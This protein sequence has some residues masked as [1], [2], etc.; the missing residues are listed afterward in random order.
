MLTAA[1]AVELRVQIQLDRTTVHVTMVTGEMEKPVVYPKVSTATC[2]EQYWLRR[3]RA[4]FN[5]GI[6]NVLIDYSSSKIIPGLIAICVKSKL[7]LC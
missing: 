4:T 3:V 2:S 5:F 7:D 6:F 1:S